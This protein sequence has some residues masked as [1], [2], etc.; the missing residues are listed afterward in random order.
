MRTS[1][2][3]RNVAQIAPDPHGSSIMIPFRHINPRSQLAEKIER[4]VLETVV[5]GGLIVCAIAAAIY[6]IGIWVGAW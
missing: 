5:I 2:G 4:A 1:R 3:A 6:D